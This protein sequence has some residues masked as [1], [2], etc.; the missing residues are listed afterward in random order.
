V[1][2]IEQIIYNCIIFIKWKITLNELNNL[3]N[4]LSLDE[5]ELLVPCSVFDRKT[6][7]LSH[8]YTRIAVKNDAQRDDWD[9]LGLSYVFVSRVSGMNRELPRNEEYL[10]SQSYAV[11][12]ECNPFPVFQGKFNCVIEAISF[13]RSHS[14]NIAAA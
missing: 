5:R 9:S 14:E 1:L 3:I 12:K 6:N 8:K 13:M 2:E 4:S 7:G 11:F 10:N